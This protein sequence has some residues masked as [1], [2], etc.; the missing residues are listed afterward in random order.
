MSVTVTEPV[1]D[2]P[3]NST[4]PLT[5]TAAKVG[6]SVV[7][8]PW[9]KALTEAMLVNS[10]SIK[11]PA[12]VTLVVSV[13]SAEASMP[14]S[15]EPSVATSRPSTVPLTAMFPVTLT[16]EEVVAILTELSWYK[17]AEPSAA[18]SAS[19]SPSY[20]SNLID[21]LPRSVRF[22]VPASSM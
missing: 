6:E 1:P 4:L 9:F 20:F 7:A 18:K 10:E 2:R 11:A 12:A 3:S 16:P 8:T 13:T 5:V 17:E 19:I 15:L 14:S 21:A 22:P